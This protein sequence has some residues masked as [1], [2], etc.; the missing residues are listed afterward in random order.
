MLNKPVHGDKTNGI[1]VAWKE[2]EENRKK[3]M[4][5]LKIRCRMTPDHRHQRKHVS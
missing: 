4:V 1:S 3:I 2:G 5:K